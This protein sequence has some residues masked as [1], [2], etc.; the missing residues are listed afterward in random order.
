M[1]KRNDLHD[2]ISG[3]YPWDAN[4]QLGE[5][6]HKCHKVECMCN[7]VKE[8]EPHVENKEATENFL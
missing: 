5:V 6:V 7:G 1:N 8:I 2:H 4:R 3:D